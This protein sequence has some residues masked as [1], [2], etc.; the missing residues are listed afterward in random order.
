M[1]KYRVFSGPYFP[2]FGLNT[3]IFSP[4]S[5]RIQENA[6]QKKLRIWTLSTQ[7]GPYRNSFM[8]E[9]T[10][11]WKLRNKIQRKVNNSI[12][13]SCFI[14]T[15]AVVRRCFAKKVFLKILQ[16]SKQN[17][18]CQILSFNKVADLRSVT[19]LKKEILAQCFFL[20]LLR[21]V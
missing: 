6:D 4:Y 2:V 15:E 7:W 20:R 16:N 1:S 19:F 10:W 9:L 18:L 12:Y 14:I 5:I 11:F 17:N 3:E 8:K 13:S 21:N